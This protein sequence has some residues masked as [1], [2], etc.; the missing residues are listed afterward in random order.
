MLN[1]RKSRPREALAIMWA[2][3]QLP[4]NDLAQG[5]KGKDVI[6]IFIIVI[7]KLY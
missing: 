1:G 5:I 2:L 4:G 3:G 6:F 7:P